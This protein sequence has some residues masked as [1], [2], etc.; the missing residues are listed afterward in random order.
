MATRGGKGIA[1][2]DSIA[3]S[4][5]DWERETSRSAVPAFRDVLKKT[6]RYA[7]HNVYPQSSILLADQVTPGATIDTGGRGGAIPTCGGRRTPPARSLHIGNEQPP[8]GACQR[9]VEG[10]CG[11]CSGGGLRRGRGKRQLAGE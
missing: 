2:A 8:V 5:I 1:K 9:R 7:R 6:P 10:R 3:D 11:D 4:M